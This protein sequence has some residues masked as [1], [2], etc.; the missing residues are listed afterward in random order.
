[1]FP[2]FLF[3]VAAHRRPRPNVDPR[4]RYWPRLQRLIC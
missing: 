1:V 2:A 3:S 4:L